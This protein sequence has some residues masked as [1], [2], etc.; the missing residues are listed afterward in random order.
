MLVSKFP[1]KQNLSSFFK[2]KGLK[3]KKHQGEIVECWHV[4]ELSLVLD[5]K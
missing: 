3:H 2:L 5:M 4:E 1:P